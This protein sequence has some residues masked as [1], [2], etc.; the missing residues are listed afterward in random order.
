[1]NQLLLPFI[2]EKNL[3]KSEFLILPENTKAVKSLTSFLQQKNFTESRLHSLILKGETLCGKSHLLRHLAEKHS[4]EIFTA[5][6]IATKNLT[7][8]FDKNR[9]YAIEN[10]ELIKNEELILNILNSANDAH[11]FLILTTQK[12]SPFQLRDLQSRWKNIQVLEI[13]NPDENSIKQ[14]LSYQLSN[15]QIKLSSVNLNFLAKSI[16][17]NYETIFSL[18]KLLEFYSGQKNKILTRDD[19]KELLGRLKKNRI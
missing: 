18:V 19:L 13:K 15:K 1:M 12:I 17:Q 16:S 8:L 7:N 3:T 4:L 5:E 11:A 14:I 2:A 6:E 9:F 10:I